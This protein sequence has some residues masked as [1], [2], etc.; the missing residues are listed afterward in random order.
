MTATNVFM[1]TILKIF[2]GIPRATNTTQ[3][4]ARTGLRAKFIAMKREDVQR[5]WTVNAVMDGKS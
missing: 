4:N 1:P 5:E 3:S 2:E